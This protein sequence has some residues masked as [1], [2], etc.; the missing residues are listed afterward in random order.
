[1]AGMRT[2]ARSLLLCAVISAASLAATT[3]MT[4]DQYVT[5]LADVQQKEKGSKE[6]IAQEQ[7]KIEGLKQQISGVEQQVS[8]TVQEKYSVLG[9][10]EQDIANAE[11]ELSSIRQ[12][13]ETLSA[14]MPEDLTKRVSDIKAQQTRLE[15]FKKK[16][17]SYLW[18][19]AQKVREVE[20]LVQQ[21]I[22]RV[23]PPPPPPQ[24]VVSTTGSKK[25]VS[26]QIPA[27]SEYGSSYSYSSSPSPSTSTVSTYTVR[28]I[29]ERRDCLFRIA[30][31]AEIYNDPMQ[32]PKLYEANRGL[33]DSTFDRYR[34]T[35]PEPKYTRA[36]DL[37]YPGQVLDVPR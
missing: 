22:D 30:G 32:W 2:F 24:I 25:P 9:V 34:S 8:S 13:L 1:M 10:T 15:D 14:L 11:G 4:Y 19:I 37:I 26:R 3:E 21:T 12:E 27:P 31:Y 5:T 35:H 28:L 29:P 17:V 7:A 36:A 6:E 16:P 33:I 20:P 23:P 18:T